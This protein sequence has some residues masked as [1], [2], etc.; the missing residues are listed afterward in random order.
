MSSLVSASPSLA[1]GPLLGR[2]ALCGALFGLALLAPP[3]ALALPQGG[4]AEVNPGGGQ[5]SISHTQTRMDVTLNASRT[6]L[7]WTSFNVKPDETVTFNFQDRNAIVL[8]RVLGLTESKIEGVVEG[9]VGGAFGG[10]VWFS[11]QNSIIVGKGAR[12]D[13]GGVLIGIGTPDVSSFLDPTNTLFSFTG[14]DTLPDAKVMVLN[15][16]T[17]TAHGG[18]VALAGPSI[19]TRAN[20]VVSAA[21][22]SVLYGAA[23]AFQIRMAPGSGGD[24]D[25]VDFIVPT[26]SDGTQ[27]SVAIDLG[28]ATSANAVFLAAVNR[29]AIGSAVINLEGLVTAQ[30][31]KADGGDIV[32]SGGGGI[33][34]RLPGPSVSGAGDTDIYLNRATASRD[35]RVSNVGRIFGRPWPRPPEEAKNPP[36]LAEDQQAQDDLDAYCE[37]N[38]FDEICGGGNGFAPLEVV[39]LDEDQ[40]A[41]LFDPTAISSISTGRDARISATASIELGR[42]VAA[43]DVAVE[44]PELKANGLV[45]N[46]D[47]SAVSTL[48]DIRLAG[49]GVMGA[50]SVTGHTDVAIDAITAPQGLTVSSGRNVTIG[51][52]VSNVSGRVIVSAP[53]NVTLNMGSGRVESVTAGVRVDLRGAAVEVGSITA[54]LVYGEAA[55]LRVDSATVGGD[56]YLVATSGDASLGSATAGDDIYVIATHG[57]ASLGDAV[58]TGLGADAIGVS[59]AGSPDTIG[60]GRVVQVQS[61]DFDARLG[62]GTGG[63]T[64]ATAVSVL[65]GQ[66]AFVEVVRETPGIFSVT[67][68]RDATLKAPNVALGSVAAGRDLS[69]GSTTGDFTLTA[70]LVALRNVS[71]SAVGALRVGNVRADQGSITLTGAS[72]TAGSVSA[73]EDLVLKATSGGVS[74]TSYAVGRDLIIQ[75]SSLSLGAAIAP[76]TRDLS[77]T[78]LGNFTSTTPLSAGRDLILDVTGKAT[79]AQ[80]SAGRTVRIV[81]GDL[82]LTGTLTAPNAQIE[83]RGGALHAGGG[84]SGA[85]FVLDGAD[86]G[87]LRVTGETRIYAGSTTGGT[88]GDLTLGDLSINTANTPRVTF[89]VGSNNDALVQGTVAPTASGGVLRIGDA[90]DLAWRPDSILVTGSLGAATFA[91]G[92]ASYTGVRAFDEV[93]LAARQDILFGSQRFITLVQQTPIGQIDIAAGLPAGVAPIGPEVGRVFVSAGRLEV[94]ADAKVVQQNTAPIGSG[95]T[96]GLFFTGQFTP[97]LIIDPPRLVELWGAFVGP[98]GQVVS[99]NTA[100]GALTFTVV[101]TSGQPTTRPDGAAYRF[102]SCDVGTTNC[103]QAAPGGGSGGDVGLVAE[104]SAGLLTTRD[105]VDDPEGGGDEGVAA[106]SSAEL[107]NPPVILAIAPAPTDEIVTDPVTA[108]AGSEEIW[109]KRRQTK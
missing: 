65:A 60:N 91:D 15:G 9:R 98:G 59:F 53:Q 73:S 48:G 81:A 24:F 109:R 74:T 18:M 23:G 96:A 69:V 89:L 8:N 46:R 100:G 25:L 49:V 101:D 63:V 2:T 108:G 66:D 97:Q 52:G 56:L 13:A 14:G 30:A 90:A 79:V 36:T 7:G 21:D 40:L 102:N 43:R 87:Q 72:V 103:A 11:S 85:G 106:V 26:A 32:L 54:P 51:D 42:I 16:A 10:N 64:G 31:A 39:D 47:L 1:R 55:N 83:S 107:A 70:D 22:G 78:S 86:F 95:G 3:E 99:G 92:G 35:L 88:R 94:S 104:M 105:L 45:A 19:V 57:I 33:Q 34:N 5:P 50:G 77:I 41:G 6:V 58:L 17:V 37:E 27:D 67:A 29:A 84:A 62:L 38:P 80:T 4:V 71:V 61:T 93:R 76:V 75:G 44:G 82:D 20:A 28:G 68:A 12:I